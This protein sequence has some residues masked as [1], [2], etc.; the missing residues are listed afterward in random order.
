MKSLLLF[1]F[2]IFFSSL[3]SQS[4]FHSD[5]DVLSYLA[6]KRTF[7][8]ENDFTLKFYD[9]GGGM[10]AGSARFFNP[11]VTIVSTTRAIVEYQNLDTIGATS[12]FIVDSRQ[13]LLMDRAS[14]H[15]FRAYSF[16]Q[17]TQNLIKQ[18][19][20]TPVSSK[21]KIISKPKSIK[22]KKNEASLTESKNEDPFEIMI[23]K[24][25]ETKVYTRGHFRH[26]FNEK[27]EMIG[28]MSTYKNDSK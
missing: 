26:Y 7:S 15:I 14:N 8:D 4:Y 21:T 1:L 2:C 27:G 11:E 6:L 16:E 23:I 19:V 24:G 22:V 3:H 28:L 12:S 20:K 10:S 9:M 18:S 13:N 17:T 5:G 25:K